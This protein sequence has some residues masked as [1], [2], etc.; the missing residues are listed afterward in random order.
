MLLRRDLLLAARNPGDWLTPLIFFLLV[1]AVFPLAVGPEPDT[2]R[3]IAP[4][5]IWSLALLSSL[6]SQD[7]IF[8]SD[9]EDGVLEQLLLSPQPL[10]LAVLAKTA[11]HWLAYCAPLVLLAPLLGV[12]LQLP[13]D[14]LGVLLLTLPLGTGI[15]SLLAAFC[16]ALLTGARRSHFLGALLALPLCLPAVIFA[17]ATV[18][19]VTPAAPL[20]LLAALFML[21]LTV[22]PIATATALRLG[23]GFR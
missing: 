15:F 19:A 13:A 2:L 22:L 21:S 4:G 7:A 1:A 6:L 10:V 9:A 18:T 11:A 17:A 23:S 20:L 8:R 3:R 12:W 16:A 5:V 14:S